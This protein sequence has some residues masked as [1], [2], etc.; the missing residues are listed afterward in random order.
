MPWFWSDQYDVRLQIAGIPFDATQVVVRG[1]PEGGSFAVFHL[2]EDDRVLA[3]EAVNAPPEFLGG[4]RMIA[5]KH[6]LRPE[7]IRDLSLSV[8]ELAA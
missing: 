6:R 4:K 7:R 8:K 5:A 2:A 1:A 3:V